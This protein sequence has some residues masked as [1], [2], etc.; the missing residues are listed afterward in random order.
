M[1]IVDSV[2]T[3]Q[4]I[5]KFTTPFN[6]M[7]AY[8]LGLID[9][10]GN[11]LKARNRMSPQEI[12]ALGLYDVLIINLKKIVA[13]LPGGMSRLGTVAATV[14][15]LRSTPI[16]ESFDI[17]EEELEKEFLEIYERLL[18]LQEDGAPAAAAAPVNSAGSGDVAGIGQPPGS[19]KGLPAVPSANRK[20]YIAGNKKGEMKLKV[21]TPIISGLERRKSVSEGEEVG[22]KTEYDDGGPD[23]AKNNTQLAK[24]V[25][26]AFK[27]LIKRHKVVSKNVKEDTTLEYHKNLNPKIWND[28]YKLKDEVRSRLILIADTWINF[29][30]LNNV[31]VYDIVI[32]GGNVNYNYT[33]N[34]DIDLHIIISR[35]DINP[36]RNFVDE[37][38]QDKK[39]LWTMQHPNISIYGYPVELY[40][41]DINEVPHLNQ[42]VYSVLQDKWLA[43]P[44]MLD[45]D[46]EN[47][48]HLQKKVQF[49]KDVIDKMITN[50]ASDSSFD[51]L[52]DKIKKMRGDS[53]AKEGEFAFGNLVF[54]DLRNAGYLDKLNDYKQKR[55]DR[56]LSLGNS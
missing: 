37:Y 43:K 51:V 29:A 45:V 9:D 19:Y 52:K 48:Y 20:A 4:F 54:K 2:L 49:Y 33:P 47:D 46:F 26:K 10:K 25:N 56:A 53:I 11:F 21:P 17:N 31:K 14:L 27:D 40:A 6:Q 38:L 42:G 23:Y 18:D 44:E 3:Y 15:L 24:G 8:K 50:N 34:S 16:K 12:S 32:T 13:R 55:M 28:D 35:N 22:I 41:Q 5:K 7:P 1:N 36:D 39:I 30:K